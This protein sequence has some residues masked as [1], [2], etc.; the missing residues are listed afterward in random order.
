MKYTD[1]KDKD[2]SALNE[3]LKEQKLLLFKLKSKL[4]TMQLSNPNEIKEVRRDI[5]RIKT[6]I[7]TAN[8]KA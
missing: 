1:I 7:T 4:R 3:L 2:A 6:A 5:A 8:A